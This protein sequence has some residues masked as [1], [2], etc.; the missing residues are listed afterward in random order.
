MKN[1]LR[2]LV[3]VAVLSLMSLSMVV[4]SSAQPEYTVGEF[5]VNLARMVTHKADYTPEQAAAYLKEVGVDLGDLGSQVD[6]EIFVG[7]FNRLGVNVVTTNPD[8][9]V[10]S[11]KADRVFQMFDA[12]DTLF[13][14]ELFKVCHGTRPNNGEPSICLNDTDCGAGI[15]CRVVGSIKCIGGTNEYDLCMSNGDCPGGVCNIPFGQL[16]KLKLVSPSD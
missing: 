14:G 3:S 12:H 4:A 7:A 11:D 16:K 9:E 6:E 10:A 13:T 8:G 2:T 1:M 15:K 5:D